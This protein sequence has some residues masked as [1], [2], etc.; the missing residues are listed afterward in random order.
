MVEVHAMRI[1]IISDTHGNLH[2][3]DAVLA[4]LDTT[5]PYDA[6]LMGGDIA[7]GGPFPNECIHRV[8]ERGFPSVRG[9]TDQMIV[10]ALSGAGDAH[11]TWVLDQ[12]DEESLA[13]LQSLPVQHEVQAD[14]SQSLGLVHATPWSIWEVMMPDEG[15][16]GFRRMLLEAGTGL[17]AYGHIHLQ[18]HRRLDTG[19]VVAV[20]SIG[21]PFDGDRRAM[22]TVVEAGSGGW[23]VEFMR[24]EY[25]IEPAIEA[26]RKAGGP[27]GESF[28]HSVST[29]Q[30][31]G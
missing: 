5:G 25:D 14:D 11:S 20:G 7:F 3:F 19:Q 27:N 21:L 26:A 22:Y 15:D 23:N 4:E 10:D 16:V 24:V 6:T 30:R 12:L 31:P 18:H 2:A 29:A 1:A 8:L 28:A 9:N 13:F 17:L